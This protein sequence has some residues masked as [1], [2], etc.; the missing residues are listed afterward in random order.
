[1][2]EIPKILLEQTSD[3]LDDLIP[4]VQRGI[5][6]LQHTPNPLLQRPIQQEIERQ[7]GLLQRIK[8]LKGKL[9]DHLNPP[10][11]VPQQDEPR[12]DLQRKMSPRGN[13]SGTAA[14]CVTM[15]DG[16]R[17]HCRYVI[18]TFIK[19]IRKL[20]VERVE[21]LGIK[22]RERFLIKTDDVRSGGL[23][24]SDGYNILNVRDT[25]KKIEI[26]KEIGN[27]LGVRLKIDDF[28]ADGLN[29]ELRILMHSL[30][31]GS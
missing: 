13:R 11:H 21:S 22:C 4:I 18:D 16:E 19:V 25:N 9:H 10:E 8:E 23:K 24:L 5:D 30:K 15:P 26:L 7:E 28:R 17:I 20:G 29:G 1:M 3:L 6:A 31:Q 27:R 2:Q 14:L 12:N